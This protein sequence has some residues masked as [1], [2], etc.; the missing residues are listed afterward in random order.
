MNFGW[1]VDQVDSEVAFWLLGL[2]IP[3]ATAALLCVSW[4]AR[5]SS[6]TSGSAAHRPWSSA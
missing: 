2:G 4:R 1:M 3:I 6:A 5:S